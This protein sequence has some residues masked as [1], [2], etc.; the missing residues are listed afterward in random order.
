MWNWTDR[1]C[2]PFLWF[3][4]Q[5]SSS[6]TLKYQELSPRV[7]HPFLWLHIKNVLSLSP[8]LEDIH[9]R[10]SLQNLLPFRRI[11]Q[12]VFT[13]TTDTGSRRPSVGPYFLDVEVPFGQLGDGSDPYY[14]IPSLH[15]LLLVEFLLPYRLDEWFPF[16]T[17]VSSI[18]QCVF[19][20]LRDQSLQWV[21]DVLRKVSV[22]EGDMY[23]PPTEIVLSSH[24]TYVYVSGTHPRS[25]RVHREST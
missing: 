10:L 14:V 25:L 3:D 9:T 7:H 16:K 20:W 17:N 11:L 5:G 4:S 21:E 24:T 6:F 12:E 19:L 18:P 1:V 23:Y 13:I 15:P 22:P 2:D 8:S